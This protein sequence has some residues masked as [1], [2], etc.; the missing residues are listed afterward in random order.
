[1]VGD[2]I[3]KYSEKRLEIKFESKE[4]IDEYGG[5]YNDE[6]LYITRLCV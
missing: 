3:D 1:M 4:G 6:Y 5:I 2:V